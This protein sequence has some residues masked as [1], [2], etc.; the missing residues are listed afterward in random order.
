MWNSRK[1]KEIWFACD[2]LVLRGCGTKEITAN[3]IGNVLLEKGLRAGSYRDRYRYKNTWIKN[4]KNIV[5]RSEQVNASFD[6]A[7]LI[8]ELEQTKIS[9]GLKCKDIEKLEINLTTV[10]REQVAKINKV[11]K[12][13]GRA[14]SLEKQLKKEKQDFEESRAGIEKKYVEQIF[15]M[16]QEIDRIKNSS[17]TAAVLVERVDELLVENAKLTEANEAYALENRWLKK[18]KARLLQCL[19]E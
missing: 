8:A 6:T 4:R 1:E 13:E 3:A 19:A 16:Q 15:H 17:G 7:K 10:N 11:K 14:R 12:L 2:E 9:L 18:D 5:S